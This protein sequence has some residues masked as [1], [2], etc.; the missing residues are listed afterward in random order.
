MRPKRFR[1][2]L[3]FADGL[4]WCIMIVP[5]IFERLL[6]RRPAPY[7][8][9]ILILELWGIGDLVMMSGVLKLLRLHFKDVEISL[10]AK[11]HAHDI[12]AHDHS[13][14]RFFFFDFPWTQFSGKYRLWAWPWGDLVRLLIKLRMEKF[15]LILDARGDIR[16]NFLAFLIGGKRRIGYDWTGGRYF[17]TDSVR[18]GSDHFHRVNAWLGILRY[19]KGDAEEIKPTLSVSYEA[20]TYL[21]NFL[22]ENGIKPHDVL[23]GIHP[24][25][26]RKVRCWPLDRYADLAAYIS[27]SCSRC[28]IVVIV[29]P[30]GYGEPLAVQHGFILFKA[31][32]EH[33]VALI[34]RLNLLI[35]NDS[36]AMHIAT[37]VDT[38]VVALFGPGAVDRIGPYGSQ[39]EIIMV[40]EMEC[41]PC[42]D[43][44]KFSEPYCLTKITVERAV[45]TID[46]VL[47]EVYVTD[48][49]NTMTVRTR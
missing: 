10:L 26:A 44:C 33:M 36:A 1:P 42:F 30:D 27:K 31:S 16:N 45:A 38:H 46:K 29:E 35:C 28:K 41:R 11:R 17:L 3:N 40:E 5:I 34:K 7:P 37:A 19:L 24:G 18:H 23:V 32:L 13:V 8:K 47:K 22:H 15:D 20:Q 12:L 39:H 25:A 9:R 2:L 43:H 4:L 14:D 6:N 49:V 48:M 21:Q